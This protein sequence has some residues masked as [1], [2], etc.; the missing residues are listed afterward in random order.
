MRQALSVRL[1]SHCWQLPPPACTSL[2]AGMQEEVL[3]LTGRNGL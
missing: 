3:A 2:E 1:N